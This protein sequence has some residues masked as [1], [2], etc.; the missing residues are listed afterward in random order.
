MIVVIS[1]YPIYGDQVNLQVTG[2]AGI[3]VDGGR[4]GRRTGADAHAGPGLKHSEFYINLCRFLI[5]TLSHYP[6]YGVRSPLPT[7]PAGS[8]E[9]STHELLCSDQSNGA[10]R[11]DYCRGQDTWPFVS[12]GAVLLFGLLENFLS[13]TLSCFQE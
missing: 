10:R 9:H 2:D 1:L 3:G 13:W 6:K 4:H 5:P 8:I 7:I 12:R 11:M